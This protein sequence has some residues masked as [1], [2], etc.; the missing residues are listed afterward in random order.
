MGLK[1]R[2]EREAEKA[3]EAERAAE[4]KIDAKSRP[5]EFPSANAAREVPFHEGFSRVVEMV[6]V[7]DVKETFDEIKEFIDAKGPRTKRDV[8]R[9]NS[10]LRKAHDLYITAKRERYVWESRNKVVFAACYERAVLDLQ[11]EKES[12]ARSK[13]VTDADVENRFAT[14]YPDE[15]ES[16]D[17]KKREVKLLEES[18]A[19]LVEVMGQVCRNLGLQ[20]KP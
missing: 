4:T 13:Q 19:N 1:S 8:D 10:L 16:Q 20:V 5:L 11:R 17:R 3:A 2:S 15:Y 6:F 14:M 7:K 18:M 9:A 12:G